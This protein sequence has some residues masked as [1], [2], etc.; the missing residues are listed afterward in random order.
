M[1][2]DTTQ[3]IS[4]PKTLEWSLRDIL[5]GVIILF[6][7]LALNKTSVF[8]V[9]QTLKLPFAIIKWLGFF[10]FIFIYSS[11]ICKARGITSLVKYKSLVNVS[12]EI[13]I[14]FGYWIAIALSTGIVV[15]TLN[16][17]IESES[18]PNKVM[19]AL[20][21]AP[22]SIIVIVI[23]VVMFTLGPIAE[24]FF[25]RGFLYNALKSKVNYIV[26]MIV[27]AFLF[28]L[29]HGYGFVESAGIF[30]FGIGLAIVYERRSN[31]LAAIF[32]HITNNAVRAVPI[33]LLVIVNFHMPAK[34]FNDA[35]VNPKWFKVSPSSEIERKPTGI[36]QWEYAINEWGSKGSREWKKEVNAFNAVFFYHDYDT[37]AC[38]KAKLGIVSVYYHYLNDY[39]RAII[40][41]DRLVET[42][43]EQREQVSSALVKKGYSYYELQMFKESRN[44]FETLVNNY[45]EFK[46]HYDDAKKGLEK[47]NAIDN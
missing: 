32:V 45:G 25:F 26:A 4:S 15:L 19:T 39:R 33:L 14:S 47:L 31:L 3:I 28:A 12:K 23:L 8:T 20:G 6:F 29:M 22:S 7:A 18:I 34:D 17:F 44:T 5:I 24:E 13:I 9:D 11:Y 36:E 10:I 46:K 42:Y 40:E 16:K 35:M 21:Y 38:A 30:V 27:Q 1:E 37:V 43:P 2:N 41:T